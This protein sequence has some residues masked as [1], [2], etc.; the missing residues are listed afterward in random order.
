[1]GSFGIPS[2]ASAV[3][4]RSL[5]RPRNL[6]PSEKIFFLRVLLIITALHGNDLLPHATVVPGYPTVVM[7]EQDSRRR[8]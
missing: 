2:V 7:G 1:L 3:C 4:Y 5:W 6:F 8:F